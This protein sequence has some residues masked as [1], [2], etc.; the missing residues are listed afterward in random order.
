MGKSAT[1]LLQHKA[2]EFKGFLWGIRIKPHQESVKHD[3]P[4][5][6]QEILKAGGWQLSGELSIGDV[7]YSYTVLA[8]LRDNLL[9]QA[10][11][12]PDA[13]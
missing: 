1:K 8:A 3:S 2:A 12:W 10:N 11:S 5:R 4:E 9:L 13:T 6:A 7:P